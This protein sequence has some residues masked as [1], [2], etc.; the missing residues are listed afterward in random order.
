ME[1]RSRMESQEGIAWRWRP[2]WLGS[3]KGLMAALKAATAFPAPYSILPRSRGS[4]VPDQLPF[5][6]YVPQDAAAEP[7]FKG[8][9]PV[10][11]REG[12]ARARAVCSRNGWCPLCA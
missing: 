6:R 1:S 2:S 9:R 12:S 3:G 4:C 11:G 8:R 7:G 5:E 10:C